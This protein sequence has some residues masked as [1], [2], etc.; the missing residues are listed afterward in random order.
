[1]GGSGSGRKKNSQNK[2]SR[3]V[4]EKRASETGS[5]DRTAAEVSEITPPT[6][7]IVDSIISQAVPLAS[8]TPSN[9]TQ[10]S[11]NKNTSESEYLDV[12]NKRS[13]VWKWFQLRGDKSKAKCI[14]CKKIYEYHGSTTTMLAHLD[15]GN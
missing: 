10:N 15:S 6:Q 9:E 4:I 12:V 14:I 3:I 2:T 8:S 13:W 11:T 7:N 5:I 1:M